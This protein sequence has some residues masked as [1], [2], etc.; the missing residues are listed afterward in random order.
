[1]NM[2]IKN[3]SKKIIWLASYPKSGNTWFRAFLTALFNEGQV[4]INDIKT[5]GMFSSRVIF[6]ACTDLDSTYLYDS[7][8]KIMQPEVFTHLAGLEFKEKL[9]IKIH[10]AY[11]NNDNEEPIIPT[12]PTQCALYF[13]R[14]PLDIAGSLANHMNITIAKAVKLMN[15]PLGSLAIQKNNRN[16]N[17]QI[18]QLMFSWSEHVTSWVSHSAFPVLVIKYEDMLLNSLKT[19]TRAVEFMEM[20]FSEDKII[21]AIQACSF[22][23][24]KQQEQEKKFKELIY[25][26]KPFFRAGKVGNGHNEIPVD[27]IDQLANL[28]KKTMRYYDYL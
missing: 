22:E 5:D 4:D 27:L 11:R 12:A 20:Q 13:I 19:F 8:V 7:E 14:N 6:D 10:D 15:D 17:V 28:H 9:F 24:L 25:P 26:D 18:E 21:N 2:E 1:M 3:N 16:T 23:K